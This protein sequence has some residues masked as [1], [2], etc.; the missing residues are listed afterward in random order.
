VKKQSF[1]V[2]I[3]FSGHF[4]LLP[5][6]ILPLHPPDLFFPP[7]VCAS[8]SSALLLPR[9][10]LGKKRRDDAF[11]FWRAF[12]RCMPSDGMKDNARIRWFTGEN[13]ADPSF[14]AEEGA[15]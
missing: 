8:I 11:F 15:L 4:L 6:L 13:G 5:V 7:G 10:I 2:D 3:A 1:L 12:L 14:M 9:P